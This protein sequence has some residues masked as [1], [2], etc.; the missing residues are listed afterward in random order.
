MSQESLTPSLDLALIGN[1]TIAALLTTDA[2]IVWSCFPTFDGDPI[3]CSLL[4]KA[5]S[6]DHDGSFA[7]ELIDAVNR[8]QQYMADT[9]I[10]VTRLYDAH[11]GAIQITDFAPRFAGDGRVQAPHL[12]VRQIEVVSGKPSVRIRVRPM[13]N[14]GEKRT[15]LNGPTIGLTT[16]APID[17]ITSETPFALEREVTLI[18]GDQSV[19]DPARAGKEFRDRTI[20]WWRDWVRSLTIP[21]RWHDAVTRAAITLKLNASEET[22]AIIA[23][24]TTSIPEAPN[25][26][27]N[28]DYRYCWLRDAYF[29]VDALHKLGDTT[30]LHRYVD[31]VTGLLA[32]VGDEVGPLYNIH[33]GPVPVERE[34]K[35]LAG[36][37]GMAPVRIGNEARV[38][39]QHDVYGEII[40]AAKLLVFDDALDQNG[41]VELFHK[42]EPLG[43]QA[44]KLFDKPDAGLW[45]LRG[46]ERAHTFSSVMCWAACN[47]LADIAEHL[48]LNERASFWREKANSMRETI[49][50]RAWNA[51]LGAF[52]SAMDGEDLDASL[53]LMDMPGFIGADDPRYVSTVRAIGRDLRR[54]DFIY[55]YVVQDDFG[56]PE[57]AF[58][59]CTFWYIDALAAIGERHEARKL[60]ERLLSCRNTHGLLSEDIDPKTHELW[61]NFVQTYSMAGLIESA[62]RLDQIKS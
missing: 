33:G 41:A 50:R 27:R 3:F 34:A 19:A 31:F 47:G 39:R 48:R 43:D 1:G 17:S 22:G 59:V 23:A 58:L 60:F 46:T 32:T 29:V 54:G 37:R 40:L 45:E 53:L 9:P 18:L 8:E 25:T 21:S 35:H 15:S 11:G 12:L 38:Q 6:A 14:Y 44:A 36:Y 5:D 61:G 57:N 13:E 24:M 52:A 62:I 4:R 10:V 51:T 42:L 49:C 56:R 55:R 7:I 2:E 26:A 30:T 16:D 20:E 28:W